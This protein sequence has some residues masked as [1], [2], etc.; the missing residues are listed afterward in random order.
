MDLQTITGYIARYGLIAVFVIVLLEYMNLPGF[1]AGIIMPA[2]G[3]FAAKGGL[4][5]IW[6]LLISMLAGLTGSWVLYFIGRLG[7]A[8]ALAW[9]KKKMPKQQERIDKIIDWINRR[10]FISV[11]ISKLLPTVRTIISLPAGVVK[12]NFAVYTV[13]SAIGI[14]IWNFVFIGAGYLFGDTVF[15]LFGK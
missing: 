10:G 5:F 11:F 14:A 4:N 7:G 3:I 2:A 9:L 1:P 13:S 8:P 12:M 15:S 6:V